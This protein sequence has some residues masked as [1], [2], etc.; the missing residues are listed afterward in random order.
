MYFI[1]ISLWFSP[2]ISKHL[3]RVMDMRRL[4]DK[5]LPEPLSIMIAGAKLHQ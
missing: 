5:K 3:V 4:G 1:E 2:T